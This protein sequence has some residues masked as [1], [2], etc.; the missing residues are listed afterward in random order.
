MSKTKGGLGR[1]LGALIPDLNENIDKLKKGDE[2]AAGE[3]VY[4]LPLADILPNPWQPRHEFDEEALTDL[5]DSIRR[6]GVLSP[7]LVVRREDDTLLVSGERRLRAAKIAGLETIPAIVRQLDD[8]AMATI[9][10]VENIQRADL[11]ALEEAQGY[12]RLMA[13]TGQSAAQVAEA[14]GKSRAHVA[15]MV[16]LLDLP[17]EVLA[18]L[19]EGRLTAGHG[20]ALLGIPD[21]ADLVALA[22][23]AAQLGYSVRQVEE[24]ARSL[25]DGNK[26]DADRK[27][28]AKAAKGQE[29][30]QEISR[31]LSEN[32]QTK[33]RI[34]K[35]GPVSELKIEFYSED[36]LTRILELLHQQLH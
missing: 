13:D 28:P 7:I 5:A 15:N 36:D 18:L 12:A 26:P 30:Y 9:A 25:K 23:E 4:D 3:A 34:H 19:A 14:V 16:R 21:P 8:R 22:L 10:L 11:N 24:L 32:L 29:V 33:V 31:Q 1:G 2:G 17:E 35:R 20:R 6:E 27:K